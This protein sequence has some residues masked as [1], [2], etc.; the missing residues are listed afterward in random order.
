MNPTALP[1][2]FISLQILALIWSIWQSVRLL[3]SDR[4]PVTAL[5]FT[6]ALISMLLSDCY[7]IAYVAIRPDIR[8]PFA[9]NEIGEWALFLLLSAALASIFRGRAAGATREMIL[10]ALFAAA[11]TALWIGWS[12]E[13]VQDIITGIV[14]GYFYCSIVRALRA[15]DIFSR[16][17]WAALGILCLLLI[18]LQALTFLLPK[19][20]GQIVDVCCY[21]LM[22][23]GI[24]A[25]FAKTIYEWKRQT[26]PE[27]L[28]CLCCAAFAWGES[29]MY[30][31]A[32]PM[33]FV[34]EAAVTIM[35]PMMTM[36]LGKVV[37]QDDLR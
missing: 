32:E 10:A 6:V 12:G 21:V 19:G 8:M 36:S 4:P 14:C 17:E 3:R 27:T 22:F 5:L 7:W 33:Y 29:C 9:V 16:R 37:L 26:A 28:F 34:A 24:I 1:A 23:A 15:S 20:A 18:L 35:I 13:W 11:S 25:F 30:M 2:I 31:S